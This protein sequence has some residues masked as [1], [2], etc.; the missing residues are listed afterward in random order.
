MPKNISEDDYKKLQG[1]IDNWSMRVEKFVAER[2]GP[3]ATARMLQIPEHLQ[4]FS[5][6]STYPTKIAQ[7]RANTMFA[8]NIQR[9]KVLEL[10]DSQDRIVRAH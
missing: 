2:L 3:M 5:I 1:E 7:D 8:L 10:I 4:Q 9:N 6:D